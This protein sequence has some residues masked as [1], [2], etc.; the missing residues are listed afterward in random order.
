MTQIDD[1]SKAFLEEFFGEANAIAW[2]QYQSAAPNAPL[3]T[4]LEPW[5]QRVRQQRSPIL[6]PRVN[7]VS[8]Q[9]AWYVLCKDP[10]E[11]RSMRESLTA[12]IGP[13]Y[14]EFNGEFATLDLNDPIDRLCK[15]K[16]GTF[17]FRL[18]VKNR[19][20]RTQVG[21]LLSMLIEFRDRQSNRSLATVK[22]IGRLL[23]DL[24][25]AILANNEASAWTVYSEIRSRGRLSATNL[26]FLQVRIHSAFE[27]WDEILL[28]PS[29]SDLLQVRRPKQLSEQL[30][31]AVYLHL[32]VKHEI[33]GDANK[34][35]DAYR[36]IESRFQNLIRSTE[37]LRSSEAIKFALIGAVASEPPKRELAAHLSRNPAIATNTAWANA[38]CGALPAT[39]SKQAVAEASLAYDDADVKYKENNFDEAL[40]LY[41]NQPQTYLSVCRVLETAVEVDTSAAAETAL[42]YLSSAS[43]EIRGRVHGR[44][45]CANNVAILARLCRQNSAGQP[46][47]ISSLTEWFEYVDESESPEKARELLDYG[48]GEWMSGLS[49]EATIVARQL[50]RSRIG[51]K[52]EVVRNAVP[53]FIRALLVDNAPNRECKPVYTALAEL[54]IY[55]DSTGA[56]DLAAIEQLIETMLTIAPN[57]DAGQNDFEFAT[58]ATV[59][60][61]NS[62]AA[63]RHFDW[64]LSMLD[65]LIDTGAQNHTNLAKMLASIVNSSRSWARRVSGEQWSFLQLLAADL[66]LSE[67]VSGIRSEM[68]ELAEWKGNQ[69]RRQF[70]GKSIAIYSLTVR[71]AKRAQQLIEG[72]FDGTTIHLLYERTFSDRMKSLAQSVDIFIV[73][74]WDAK[75][76]ATNGIKQ[77][78]HGLAILEP[79]SKSATSLLQT[80]LQH[81]ERLS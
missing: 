4:L 17:V 33:A 29:L 67:M 63:P 75:H 55:D 81:A 54:L 23:R 53:T 28:L 64:A 11:A 41:L 73:N 65:L 57:H 27:H 13:T 15:E 43:D 38:L 44:R 18:I 52:A 22:P 26:A 12:F 68:E 69:N 47:A 78:R 48:I 21:K 49:F 9:T 62:I 42:G 31:R 10:R 14:A 24:E 46:T 39:A 60:L 16:S 1:A 71:I 5:V 51:R 40:S 72:S 76:A 58:D 7:A 59:Y 37:S 70:S 30:A 56:D 34:A 79:K 61:W 74:T 3:R 35:V 66:G 19:D 32:F 8:E 20:N 77:H 2:G 6:L 36:G 25:M 80:L 50:R 45:V